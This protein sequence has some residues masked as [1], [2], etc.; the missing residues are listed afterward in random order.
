MLVIPVRL[1]RVRGDGNEATIV[2]QGRGKC[3]EEAGRHR[4]EIALNINFQWVGDYMME[5][6]RVT[7]GDD[8]ERIKART[9]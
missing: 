1:N 5:M 3:A 8:Q 9:S 7:M 4:Q 6:I 2:L